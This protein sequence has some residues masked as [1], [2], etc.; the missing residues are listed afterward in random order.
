LDNL[1][2]AQPA[3]P[4][5]PPISL[6][7]FI[8]SIISFWAA[9]SWPIYTNRSSPSSD[10]LDME[11]TYRNLFNGHHLFP[12]SSSSFKTLKR[13]LLNMEVTHLSTTVLFRRLKLLFSA[14]FIVCN[15]HSLFGYPIETVVSPPWYQDE[16]SERLHPLRVLDPSLIS[17][18][19]S[20]K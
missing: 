12:S 13:L 9:Y 7:V 2:P 8:H 20:S 18:S 17:P 11:V 14:P 5:C 6:F 16:T 3:S 4:S 19:S 15:S 10:I 1:G